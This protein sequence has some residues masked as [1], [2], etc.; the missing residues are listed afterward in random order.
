MPPDVPL[1]ERLKAVKNQIIEE[2]DPL[3]RAFMLN[4]YAAAFKELDGDGREHYDFAAQNYESLAQRLEDEC[5][6]KLIKKWRKLAKQ[7]H[8]LA[9]PQDLTTPK[10]PSYS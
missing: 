2:R 6:P 9:N 7:Y 4:Q 1:V 10:P 3:V 5:P 8:A